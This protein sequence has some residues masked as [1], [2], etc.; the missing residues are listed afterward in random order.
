VRKH[1][2][3]GAASLYESA[4]KAMGDE[5]AVPGGGWDRLL[6]W[7]G[8]CASSV[9]EGV[10]QPREQRLLAP[11]AAADVTAVAALLLLL[12]LARAQASATSRRWSWRR[13][14]TMT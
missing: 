7:S 6:K 12:L 5:A 1:F 14:S 3:E 10:L 2:P 13:T 11:A 8:A 4:S 9:C